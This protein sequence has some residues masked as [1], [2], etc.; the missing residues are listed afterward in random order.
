[1]S[2]GEESKADTLGVLQTKGD[3]YTK[4]SLVERKRMNDLEVF[5]ICYFLKTFQN[6]LPNYKKYHDYYNF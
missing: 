2:L 6:M 3:K 5:F 4:L 1:M